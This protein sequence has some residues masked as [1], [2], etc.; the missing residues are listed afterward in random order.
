MLVLPRLLSRSNFT[1]TWLQLDSSVG[2]SSDS[3]VVDEGINGCEDDA[4]RCAHSYSVLIDVFGRVELEVKCEKDEGDPVCV[5]TGANQRK[6]LT[7]ANSTLELRSLELKEGVGEYGAGV[8]V[9]FGSDIVIK[10]CKF[11]DNRATTGSRGGAIYVRTGASVRLLGTSFLGNTPTALDNGEKGE[12]E[13][14][15]ICPSGYDGNAKKKALLPTYGSILG[16]NI[17]N[18]ECDKCRAGFFSE[19]D[20]DLCKACPAGFNSSSVAATNSTVCEACVEGTYSASGS[21]TCSVC[22]EGKYTNEI[23]SGECIKCAGGKAI[24][25]RGVN[26]FNH[27]SEKDCA[28]CGNGWYSGEGSSSCKLCGLG[29]YSDNDQNGGVANCTLCPAGRYGSTEGL[30]SDECTGPCDVGFV[31]D[32]GEARAWEEQSEATTF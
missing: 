5:I 31:C 11:V 27:D 32:A 14:L 3:V 7:V 26:R 19:D 16:S 28:V 20:G 13:V 12:I 8:D 30:E 18:Y 2:G 1:A 29:K 4:K 9:N 6:L 23:G 21:A 25:D 17:N 22:E 24:S 15:A 10:I